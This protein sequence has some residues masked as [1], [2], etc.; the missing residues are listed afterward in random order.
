M[1]YFILKRLSIGVFSIFFSLILV[2][3]LSKNIPGDP[4]LLAINSNNIDIN[5]IEYKNM[6][7]KLHLDLPIFYFTFI[8]NNN[9]Q[10]LIPHIQ[11]FGCNNQFHYWLF[12]DKKWFSNNNYTSK[13]FIRGDFGINYIDRMPI[14]ESFKHHF[15]IT[16]IFTT[17]SLLLIYLTAIPLGLLSG[18]KTNSIFDNTAMFFSL[19]IYALPTF[20]VATLLVVFFAGN[21][22]FDFIEIQGLNNN[23]NSLFEL[24]IYYIKLY[25]AP[26]L[27]LSMT[28]IAYLSRQI[29]AKTIQIYNEDFIQTARAKG[30]SENKILWKHVFPNTLFPLITLFA[31]V[32]PASIS[33]AMVIEYVFNIDG[34]GLYAYEAIA[35]R[36]YNIIFTVF[37]FTSFLTVFGLLCSDILYFLVDPRLRNNP[38]K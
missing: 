23:N 27:C 22:K 25:W 10:K 32:F 6:Q 37:F 29:R 19:I 15:G 13:G 8:R 33:G 35:Q 16:F 31:N 14:N 11:F 1:I 24:I 18:K 17:I 36:N 4:V 38:H 9:W 28:S 34:M 30:L 3:I 21:G 26:V 2:F 12:G 7:H 20:W 5:S